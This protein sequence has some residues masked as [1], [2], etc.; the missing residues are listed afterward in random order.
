MFNSGGSKD[1]IPKLGI[2]VARREKL[3]VALEFVNAFHK[4][5]IA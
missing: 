3:K 5:Y 1:K 2:I 4:I